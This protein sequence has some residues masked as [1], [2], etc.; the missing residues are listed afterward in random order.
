M[1]V[2]AEQRLRAAPA[3]SGAAGAGL[4]QPLAV[5]LSSIPTGF[6]ATGA[7]VL[8]TT[9]A[10]TLSNGTSSETTVIANTN[11]SGVASV[12]LTLPSSPGTVTVSAQ[13][14]FALGGTTVSF[15]E[16]AQ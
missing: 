12:T 5:T 15:I 6:S 10:G 7:S 13:S 3:Q 9:S 16:T 8:F 2:R 4:S 11:S 1:S 14:Q